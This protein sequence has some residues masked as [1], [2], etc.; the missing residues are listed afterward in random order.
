MCAF[1][2]YAANSFFLRHTAFAEVDLFRE[3]GL[4]SARHF[5]RHSLLLPP[6]RGGGES[7]FS[8]AGRGV[9]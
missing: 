9:G 7:R 5:P 3:L 2:S 1:T 8:C 4:E 6:S